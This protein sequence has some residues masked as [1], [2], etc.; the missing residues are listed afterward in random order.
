MTAQLITNILGM[1]ALILAVFGAGWLNQNAMNK[2][3]DD[4]RAYLDARFNAMDAKFDAKFDAVNAK[5][6]T[7]N[8]RLDTMNTRMD[9]MDKRL[10]QFNTRLERLENILFKPTLS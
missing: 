4:L 2:R 1:A 7:V 8:A 9:G 5:F 3:I 10:D 6:D